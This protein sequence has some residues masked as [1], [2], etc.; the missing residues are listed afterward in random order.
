MEEQWKTIEEFP[1]YEVSTFARIRRRDVMY[2]NGEPRKHKL[3]KM[4]M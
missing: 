3:E 1:N 4:G 2:G